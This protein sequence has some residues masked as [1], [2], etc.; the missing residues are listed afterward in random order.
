MMI[1]V[2]PRPGATVMP[3]DDDLIAAVAPLRRQEPYLR[4]GREML[5]SATDVRAAVAMCG[6]L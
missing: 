2:R 5:N 3:D 4:A 6:F 1:L